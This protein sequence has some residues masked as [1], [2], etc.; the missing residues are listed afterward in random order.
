MTATAEMIRFSE[1][2]PAIVRSMEVEELEEIL[3]RAAGLEKILSSAKARAKELLEADEE[4]FEG[5]WILVP[6]ASVEKIADTKLAASRILALEKADD[7]GKVIS[8]QELLAHATFSIT[9][10]RGVLKERLGVTAA[11][12]KEL[13]SSTLADAIVISQNAPSLKRGKVVK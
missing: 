1:L 9:D 5:R 10:I 4:A 13:T 6:G 2:D 3:N 8:A 11:E 7:T 12:A